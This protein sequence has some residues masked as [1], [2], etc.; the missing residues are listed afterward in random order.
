MVMPKI[1]TELLLP[2]MHVVWLVVSNSMLKAE[3][4][5]LFETSV[6]THQ[7][8]CCPADHMN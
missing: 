3:A 8:T 2:V 4:M 1:H 7:T 6:S 5:C